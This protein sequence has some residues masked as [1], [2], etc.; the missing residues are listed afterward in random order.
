[1]DNERDLR[2][3]VWKSNYIPV[4]KECGTMNLGA[5]AIVVWDT[6]LKNWVLTNVIPFFQCF[7]CN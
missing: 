7:F 4:C 5:E 2:L 6:E 3:G 1:M